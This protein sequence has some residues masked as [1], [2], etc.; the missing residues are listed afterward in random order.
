MRRGGSGQGLVGG[1]RAQ[2]S[3]VPPF[4]QWEGTQ[5]CGHRW[6]LERAGSSGEGG[7]FLCFTPGLER[8]GT[9]VPSG[10]Q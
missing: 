6:G 5:D 3:A 9:P 2:N 1:G 7:V 4:S 10:K 8:D